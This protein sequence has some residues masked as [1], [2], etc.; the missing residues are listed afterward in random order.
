MKLQQVLQRRGNKAKLISS[1]LMESRG[2]FIKDINEESL[3]K[4][5][6]VKN[7]TGSW[8]EPRE[9]IYPKS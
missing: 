2:L 7:I 1:V 6:D 9:A 5:F 8:E 4:Q 3:C